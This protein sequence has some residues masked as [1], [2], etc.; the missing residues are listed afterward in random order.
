MFTDRF[1][2]PL[3][4]GD[5]VVIA[6]KRGRRTAGASM[7]ETTVLG[8]VPLIPHRDNTKPEMERVYDRA[9]GQWIETGKV[10]GFHYMRAD[11][12]RQGVPTDFYRE[13]N[14]P[15]DKLYVL[16]YERLERYGKDKGKPTGAKGAY[17]NVHDVI[18][19]PA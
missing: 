14:E 13:A 2:Q 7:M 8:L 10:A 5:R 4:V 11:Q 16:H 15:P 9:A 3:N 12:D 1:G 6:V 19:V 18:K 17:D